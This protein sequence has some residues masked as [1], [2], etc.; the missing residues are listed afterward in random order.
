M[1]SNKEDTDGRA[2]VTTDAERALN[3]SL[4]KV[5]IEKNRIIIIIIVNARLIG[6]RAKS[7]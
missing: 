2:R 1:I 4:D 7:N 3:E 6:W 5:R